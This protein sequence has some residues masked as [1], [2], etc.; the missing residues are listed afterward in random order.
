MTTT[1]T[2]IHSGSTPPAQPAPQEI[3]GTVRGFPAQLLE[4]TRHG[5][6][7]VEKVGRSPHRWSPERERPEDDEAV[8]TAVLA[9]VPHRSFRERPEDD[10][11]I[12]TYT[13]EPACRRVR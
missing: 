3:E 1:A 7:P 10:E 11:V 9:A 4:R 13:S 12:L 8:I 6:S 2:S 5:A